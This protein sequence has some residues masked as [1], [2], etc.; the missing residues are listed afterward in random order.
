MGFAYCCFLQMFEKCEQYLKPKSGPRVKILHLHVYV[1]ILHAH[2]MCKGLLLLSAKAPCR[3]L[4][5]V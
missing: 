2:S 5:H 4:I 1:C 3:P